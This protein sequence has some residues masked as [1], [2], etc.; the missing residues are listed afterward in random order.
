MRD[1]LIN[2]VALEMTV[3]PV[4]ED[5]GMAPAPIDQIVLSRRNEDGELVVIDDVVFGLERNS[6]GTLFGGIPSES[7]P[8]TYELNLTSHFMQMRRGEAPTEIYVTV[9]FRSSS[10]ARMV[11]GG[12]SHLTDPLKL[13]VYYTPL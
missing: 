3:V 12:P 9:L 11:L 10:A 8:Y 6:L 4:P 7:E 1:S 2:R 5:G 13:K